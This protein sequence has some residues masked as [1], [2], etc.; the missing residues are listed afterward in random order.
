MTDDLG[1]V[2]SFSLRYW[3]AGLA[4]RGGAIGKATETLQRLAPKR[5]RI[6]LSLGDET[7]LLAQRGARVTPR[8]APAPAP[9]QASRR[10]PTAT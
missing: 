8:S 1:L 7:V 10:Q 2:R 6:S 4:E 5:A 3:M 9:P